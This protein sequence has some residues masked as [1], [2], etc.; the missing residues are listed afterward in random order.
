[1]APALAAM[2]SLIDD[3]LAT[4]LQAQFSPEAGGSPDASNVAGDTLEEQLSSIPP[5]WHEKEHEA[6]SKLLDA[7]RA[8][9]GE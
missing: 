9:V 8:L 4:V 2:P 6:L 3:A 7:R 1:M 5:T